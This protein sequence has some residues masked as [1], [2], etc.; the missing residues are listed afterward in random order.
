M[1]KL[2]R[3]LARAN[4]NGEKELRIMMVERDCYICGGNS[5]GET[6]PMSVYTRFEC[7]ACGKFRI[8]PYENKDKPNKDFLASFLYYSKISPPIAD[9]RYFCFFGSKEKFEEIQK[10]CPYARFVTNQEAENWYPKTFDEKINR[11]LLGFSKLS[12][13]DSSSIEMTYEQCCSA[14]FVKICNSDDSEITKEERDKQIK[15]IKNHLLES[16]FIKE[17]KDSFGKISITL[18]P[19]GLRKID[20]LKK[21]IIK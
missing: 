3:D 2:S 5:F 9:K 7:K 17:N 16:N 12:K 1:P 20:E 19:A 14:F 8:G 21:S 6:D 15:L 4:P 18:L 10:E 13:Y 11:I